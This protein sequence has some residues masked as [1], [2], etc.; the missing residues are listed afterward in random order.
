MS[1]SG[2]GSGLNGGDFAGLSGGQSAA[3]QMGSQLD[4]G[5]GGG[6]GGGDNNAL[7]AQQ[8]ALMAMTGGAPAGG[9]DAGAS[10]E[11]LMNLLTRQGFGGGAMGAGMGPGIA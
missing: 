1:G 10:R 8:Q 3:G 2:N 9:F 5:V 6:Q 7:L 11:A 4:G